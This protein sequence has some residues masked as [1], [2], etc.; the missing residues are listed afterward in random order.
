MQ[1][2]LDREEL[3]KW[4]GSQYYDPSLI[5]PDNFDWNERDNPCSDSYYYYEHFASRNVISSNIGLMAMESNPVAK[6]LL[7]VVTNLETASPLSG[8]KVELFDYQQQYIASGISDAQGM[9]RLHWNDV[10]PFLAT[11]DSQKK[12][13]SET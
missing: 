6:E 3:A 5:I 4:E 12:N 1:S 13:L 9:V 11:T 2:G 7:M 8:A 10:K